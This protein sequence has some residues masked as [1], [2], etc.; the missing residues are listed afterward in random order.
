MQSPPRKEHWSDI[1]KQ[2]NR[3]ASPLRPCPEDVEAI[4]LSLEPSGGRCLLLGVTAEFADLSRRLVAIDNDAAMIGSLWP[5]NTAG[6][7]V[8]RGNWLDMPFMAGCFDFIIGD[9]SLTLLSYPLEYERVFA[10]ASRVLNPGGKILIRLFASPEAAESCAKVCDHALRGRIAGFHAFKWRLAMAAAAESHSPNI[11]VVD[12]HS[13]FDRFLPDRK[14]LAKATGWSDEDIATIDLYRGSPARYSYPTLAQLR[15][16]FA[17]RF[18]ETGLR[19]GSYELAER[20]PILTL[21][22]RE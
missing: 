12:V 11:R 16:V 4:R 3:W 20:C 7:N 8:V 6:R 5:G 17:Q 22:P 18:N 15:H 9:G 10:E 1:A 2:W 19:Y 14:R 21:E 13:V